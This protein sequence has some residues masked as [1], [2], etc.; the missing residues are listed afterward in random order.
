[1]QDYQSKYID[2]YN[3]IVKK[4]NSEKES[5]IDDIVFEIELI[6][7]VEV[8]I[9]YILKLVMEYLLKNKQDEELALK[10]YKSIDSSIM[11]RNKKELIEEFINITNIN[12]EEDG[13]REWE[14]YIDKTK[15]KEITDIIK[16]ENLKEKDTLSYINNAFRDGEIK[17]F[18]FDFDKLLPPIS[19]F[20]REENRQEKK[21]SIADKLIRFFEKF[22]NIS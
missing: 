17:T 7:Q 3:K 22:Y 10:I 12:K 6:K 13:Y 14:H 5:I 11:L 15:E 18:G 21:N 19:R 16:A 2:L 8:N 9:D 1:M 20:S 4:V